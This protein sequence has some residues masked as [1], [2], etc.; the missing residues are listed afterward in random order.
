[1]ILWFFFCPIP[2]GVQGAEW[3]PGQPNLVL[4][5]EDNNPAHGRHLELDDLWGPFQVKP[6]YKIFWL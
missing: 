4:D 1:M 2:G 6:F 3:G 5:L